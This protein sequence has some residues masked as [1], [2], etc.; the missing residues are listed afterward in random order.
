MKSFEQKII[1]LLAIFL[2]LS[3][4]SAT[5]GFCQR[6]ILDDPFQDDTGEKLGL[7]W[8]KERHD[9]R[10]GIDLVGCHGRPSTELESSCN[11]YVGDTPCSRALPVLCV[12]KTGA[13]RPGY[14]V[15][16]S[17]HS[18][19]KESY[20]GWLEGELQLTPPVVGNTLTS[21]DQ[22]NDL[23]SRQFGPGYRMAEFHDGRWVKE[24]SEQRFFGDSWPEDTNEGGWNFWGYGNISGESRFWVYI[25]DQ[26]A[27]CWTEDRAKQIELYKKQLQKGHDLDWI[28]PSAKEGLTP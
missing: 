24:M 19:V 16:S 23:C 2:S 27:N 1:L 9:D 14:E 15:D 25:R 26:Q 20:R 22:A 21:L 12:K 17:D 18:W 13:P 28:S 10:F 4:F 8:G 11:A 6:E 5:N 7:T 3:L